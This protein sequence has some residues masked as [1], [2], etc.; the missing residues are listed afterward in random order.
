MKEQHRLAVCAEGGLTAAQ[1]PRA[2]GDQGLARGANIGHLVT[3]MMDTAGWVALEK[4]SDRRALSQ[5]MQQFDLGVGKFD[6]HGG[7]SVT[8]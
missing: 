1:H 2:P 5:G 8:G 4:P 6:E 3:D 7:D